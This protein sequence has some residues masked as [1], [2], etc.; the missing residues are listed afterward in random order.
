MLAPVEDEVASR[1]LAAT[2]GEEAMIRTPTNFRP[3]RREFLK[4][5]RGLA[6][7]GLAGEFIVDS[8]TQ[9]AW[10]AEEKNRGHRMKL[11]LSVRVA[12]AFG[13]KEKSSLTI[14]QLIQL[15]KRNGYEALCMRGSQAG[16][17]STAEK[18]RGMS[19][20]IRAAGLVVSMVTGDFAVPR[21]D[22]HGPDGLR[23]ITPYLDL[24]DAFGADLI[25]ICMKKEE[26]IPWAKKASDE[27][28]ERKIRLAHQSHCGSLFETVEGSLRVLKAVG[29]QNFGIIYEPANWLIAGQ[30]YGSR[31]I[32]KLKPYIFNVYVQNHRLRPG[33]EATINTWTRGK[34]KLDH[35]GLWEKGGVDSD[36]VFRGLH[37]IGYRGYVTVHQAFAGIM[38]IETAVKRSADYLR[39]LIRDRDD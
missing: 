30:N 12:E 29:R 7:L 13:S 35:I 14:D 19:E 11:S 24:A 22:E 38:P 1:A 10:A 36:D 32:R 16:I 21:N 15:A 18:V 25:R 9:T 20:K 4:A 17:H 39:P 31:T 2:W 34:V 23:N 27:A 28:R 33:G 37:E 8:G 6:V 26:D 3:N 5:A